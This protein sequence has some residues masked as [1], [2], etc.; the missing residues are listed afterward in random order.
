MKKY[1]NILFTKVILVPFTFAVVNTIRSYISAK[2]S[3]HVHVKYEH[4]VIKRSQDTKR[5][6]FN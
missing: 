6:V 5:N 2:T 1:F 3:Q 4:Y